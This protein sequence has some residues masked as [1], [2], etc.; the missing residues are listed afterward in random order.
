MRKVIASLESYFTQSQDMYELDGHFFCKVYKNSLNKMFSFSQALIFSPSPNWT[1]K[2]DFL[3][4]KNILAIVRVSF[5]KWNENFIE[6]WKKNSWLC[7]IILQ[8]KTKY[9]VTQFISFSLPLLK[10]TI[11]RIQ[12][13]GEHVKMNKT[14]KRNWETYEDGNKRWTILSFN[15]RTYIH[16][17]FWGIKIKRWMKKK[18]V[19]MCKR[20]AIEGVWGGRKENT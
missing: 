9:R 2:K 6:I 12:T 15:L 20:R 5:A 16:R 8:V 3:T 4:L 10:K 18:M 17:S 7:S 1:A 19:K 11:H 13:C 14:R